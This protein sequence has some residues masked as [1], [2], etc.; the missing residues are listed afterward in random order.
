MRAEQSVLI[1][2]LLLTGFIPLSAQVPISYRARI[3][4]RG[5]PIVFEPAPRRFPSLAGYAESL[6]YAG[7][8]RLLTSGSELSLLILVSMHPSMTTENPPVA[9]TQ[10]LHWRHS[11][12]LRKKVRRSHLPDHSPLQMGPPFRG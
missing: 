9:F 1:S 3:V 5:L 8:P 10:F 7:A 2:S 11:L 4:E 6:C 12:H